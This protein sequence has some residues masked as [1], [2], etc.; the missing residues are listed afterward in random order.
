MCTVR[1]RSLVRDVIQRCT[2]VHCVGLHISTADCF[3]Q[4]KHRT[5]VLLSI[6]DPYE[7]TDRLVIENRMRTI[8]IECQRSCLMMRHAEL[9]MSHDVYD[10][11]DL[12]LEE[13]QGTHYI[14]LLPSSICTLKLQWRSQTFI[15]TINLLNS[16]AGSYLCSINTTAPTVRFL[17]PL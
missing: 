14:G 6:L 10:L 8:L 16:F 11:H 5:T 2:S 15:L 3:I 12:I 17:N 7:V 1:P 9:V 13:Q 4:Y